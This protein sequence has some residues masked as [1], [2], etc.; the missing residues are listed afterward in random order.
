MDEGQFLQVPVSPHLVSKIPKAIACFFRKRYLI[1][2][3]SFP[4][5]LI[6]PFV[7]VFVQCSKAY[8]C[9]TFQGGIKRN[10]L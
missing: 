6:F 8:N 4:V 10:F 2:A 1:D 5:S 3:Q 9:H 7:C